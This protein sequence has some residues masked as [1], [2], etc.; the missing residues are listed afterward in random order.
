[1]EWLALLCLVAHKEAE[2]ALADEAALH[3]LVGR[4]RQLDGVRVGPHRL[5]PADPG[6]GVLLRRWQWPSHLSGTPAGSDLSGR[7][8]VICMGSWQ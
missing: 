6:Q 5:H 4:L 2:L 8:V 7:L 3:V 1:M